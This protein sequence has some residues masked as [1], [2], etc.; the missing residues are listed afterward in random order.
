MQMLP[1]GIM[2]PWITSCCKEQPVGTGK[3]PPAQARSLEEW[4]LGPGTFAGAETGQG[5]KTIQTAELA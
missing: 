1:V 3:G 5:R 2:Q 4:D